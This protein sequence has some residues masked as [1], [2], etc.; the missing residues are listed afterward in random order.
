MLLPKLC[1]SWS[2]GRRGVG[3]LFFIMVLQPSSDSHKELLDSCRHTRWLG[4]SSLRWIPVKCLT[5]MK[6]S[7]ILW[8]SCLP[9]LCSCLP[10][11][12]LRMRNV[13]FT[14]KLLITNHQ[15]KDPVGESVHG[16]CM[17]GTLH[18]RCITVRCISSP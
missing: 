17:V 16:L 1:S 10:C 2:P 7:R 13:Y 4:P 18:F 3:G 8:V 15:Y 9:A 14:M 11:V 5:T 12:C 6:S